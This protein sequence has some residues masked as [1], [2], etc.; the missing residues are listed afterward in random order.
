MHTDGFWDPITSTLDWCEANYQFS[1]YIAELANSFSNLFTIV[2]AF[3]GVVH[4]WRQGLPLNHTVSFLLFALV[5]IGSFAFHASLLYSAQLADELPMIYLVSHGFF[6]LFDTNPGFGTL[7]DPKTRLLLVAEVLFDV[8]F[9][10]SYAVVYRNPVYHQVVFGLFDTGMVVRGMYLMRQAKTE[11]D[12]KEKDGRLTA[13]SAAT[14]RTVRDVVIPRSVRKDMRYCLTAGVMSF[15]VG[16]ALW[17]VDN[18][19]CGNVTALK[20]AVGWP[21]AFLIEGHAWWHVCTGYGAFLVFTGVSYIGVCIKDDYSRWRM[22]YWYTLPLIESVG[23][24][25]ERM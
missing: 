17:N 14:P 3:F 25:K 7:N 23:N 12:P 5:G 13:T 6:S 24:D 16:F 21:G 15:M 19:F 8:L 20:R 9:T 2:L 11:E 22:R 10:W 18:V 1:Y 4:T